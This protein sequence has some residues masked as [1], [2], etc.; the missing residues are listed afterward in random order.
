MRWFSVVSCLALVA[1]GG[2]SPAAPVPDPAAPLEAL[3]GCS[4]QPVPTAEAPEGFIAPEGTIIQ[5]VTPQKPLVNVTAYIAATPGKVRADY[6]RIDGIEV[7]ISED[8]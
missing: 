1:C 7:L 4:E 6:S 3:P 2:G 8:E 5:A